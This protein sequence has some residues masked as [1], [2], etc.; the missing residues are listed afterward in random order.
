M[1]EKSAI[2][3]KCGLSEGLKIPVPQQ[4]AQHWNLRAQNQTQKPLL[5]PL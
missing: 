5:T 3:L 2:S 4:L 1:I